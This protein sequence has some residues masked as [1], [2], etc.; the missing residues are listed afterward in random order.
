M[1]PPLHSAVPALLFALSVLCGSFVHAQEATTPDWFKK[2]DR[3]GDGHI[4]REEMPKLF[5]QIDA[6][7][8]GSGSL[9]EVTAYFEKAQ[10]ARKPKSAARDVLPD[11]VE[12]RAVTIWSDG[13]RMAGDLYLPKNRQESEK[14]PA[15]VLCAGTATSCSPSTIAAGARAIRSSWRW[16]KCPRPMKRA[17]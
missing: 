3:D 1:T 12:K 6:D 9:A 15:I 16:R 2:L 4:S 17:R 7:K 11:S 5:D 13:T 14:L 8:D 10:A